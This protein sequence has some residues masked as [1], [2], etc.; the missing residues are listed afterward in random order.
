MLFP[1][2]AWKHGLLR[3]CILSLPLSL[4]LIQKGQAQA[5]AIAEVDGHI[6]DQSGSAVAGAQV[7]IT[8]TDKQQVHTA[9]SDA[10]GRYALPNLPVGNYQL[11]VTA[12]GFKTY[13][14]QGIVLQVGNNVQVNVVLQ[15]GAVSESV[16]GHGKR[17]HGGDQ[18]Q[19]DFTGNRSEAHSRPA[20]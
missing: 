10:E 1:A 4:L 13:V 15:I 14:Q 8:E 11:E 19:C 16:E 2:R 9:V 7:K 3:L 12:S 20:S 5:V 18:R 6:T 17:Q